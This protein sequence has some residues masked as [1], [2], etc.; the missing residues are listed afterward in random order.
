VNRRLLS[1]VTYVGYFIIG[2]AT[3][4]V[5]PTLPFIMRDFCITTGVAGAIFTVNAAGNFV[6]VLAG[7]IFSDLLGKK[8]LIILGCILQVIG[9]AFTA[10]FNSWAFILVLS[11]VIGLG[12]GFLNTSF[13]ALISDINAHRKGA[14]FNTL[15][16]IY[17]VGSLVGPA[18]I[19][20]LLYFDYGWRF[21]YYGIAVLWLLYVLT[22]IPIKYPSAAKKEKA[23]IDS[24]TNVYS[25][26]KDTNGSKM[27]LIKTVLINPAFIML[28]MVSF[29]YNG[30]AGSLTGWINTYLEGGKNTILLGAGM[31]SIFYLGISLGRFI[32]RFLSEKIGYLK[33]I[34][35]CSL[36]CLIFYPLIIFE[37]TPVLIAV[38]VFFSGL[39][40]S[41]LHPTGMAYA[42]TLFPSISGTVSGLLATALS[43]G[44]MTIPWIV[45]LVAEKSNFQIGF[46]IGYVLVVV[47]VGISTILLLYGKKQ[48]HVQKHVHIISK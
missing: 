34:L 26:E 44:T 48:S 7:G 8:P 32:C 30:S 3:K 47:L 39:S 4:V 40:F 12:R 14:A 9:L 36:G 1:F 18:F 33:T 27:A 6:G 46:T 45:G 13:N 20:F 11:F 38:S 2:V 5:A 21:V 37:V 22:V 31:L 17:G 29:I 28:F 25:S 24:N 16:G 23:S 43:L 10:K 41:G 15:H 42:N 35:V 19:G